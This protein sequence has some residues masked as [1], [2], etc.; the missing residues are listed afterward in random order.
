MEIWTDREVQVVIC[1]MQSEILQIDYVIFPPPGLF[2]P[3]IVFF[4]FFFLLM[5]K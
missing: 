2:W 5:L 3:N 4:F 1:Y